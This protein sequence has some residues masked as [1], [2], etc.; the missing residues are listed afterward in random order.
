MVIGHYSLRFN[1]I[2]N[3]LAIT[4]YGLRSTDQVD[5]FCFSISIVLMLLIYLKSI[6]HTLPEAVKS[7]SDRNLFLFSTFDVFAISMRQQKILLTIR[8]SKKNHTHCIG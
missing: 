8:F 4:D 3:N 2:N 7:Y 1:E 6:L 5:Y